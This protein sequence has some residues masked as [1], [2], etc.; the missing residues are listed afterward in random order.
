MQDAAE[1][2][3]E[4]AEQA[5][6]ERAAERAAERQQALCVEFCDLA[7][8]ISGGVAQHDPLYPV[9]ASLPVEQLPVFVSAEAQALFAALK[10]K[11][12]RP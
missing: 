9:H 2:R 1:A 5:E 7:F 8:S 6:G 10:A 3:R 11:L 12:V 4:D